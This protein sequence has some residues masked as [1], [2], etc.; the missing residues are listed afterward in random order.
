MFSRKKLLEKR[1]EVATKLS[2]AIEAM[3]DSF[4][5]KGKIMTV[6]FEDDRVLLEL[7]VAPGVRVEDV[8]SLKR[9]LALVVAAPTGKITMQSPIPGTSRIGIA[10]PGICLGE[11]VKK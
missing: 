4:G 10:I 7:S 1:K 5:I 8:E 3:L 9:T 2:T 11:K 6:T